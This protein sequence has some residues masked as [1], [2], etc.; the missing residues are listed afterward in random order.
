MGSQL[1]RR[2]AVFGYIVYT[3]KVLGLTSVAFRPNTV[4]LASI[5][6]ALDHTP[7]REERTFDLRFRQLS[8]AIDVIFPRGVRRA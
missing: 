2:L 4:T 3:D 1:C 7:A 6:S 8:Q 5:V